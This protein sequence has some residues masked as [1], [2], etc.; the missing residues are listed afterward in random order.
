M[1]EQNQ[2]EFTPRPGEKKAQAIKAG[3]LGFNHSGKTMSALLMAR[4]I[5]GE[6]GNIIVVDTHNGQSEEYIGHPEIGRFQ[7]ID[8]KPPYS[9][10]RMLDAARSA[11]KHGADV[12]II[13]SFSNEWDGEGGVLQF[14]D[15][16]EVRLRKNNKKVGPNVWTEPKAY[17]SRLVNYLLGL[18]I[19]V[20]LCI[21]LKRVLDIESK[22]SIVS[23]ICDNNLLYELTLN[24]TIDRDTHTV[25][26][27][28]VGLRYQDCVKPGQK[29][30]S[31]TG[32]LLYAE[33]SKGH[34]DPYE[35]Q[36]SELENAARRGRDILTV[37]KDRMKEKEFEAYRDLFSRPGTAQRLGSLARE[38]DALKSQTSEDQETDQHQGDYDGN[39]P[40]DEPQQQT[41]YDDE[42]PFD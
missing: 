31:E 24:L 40:S 6:N 7:V 5:A 13:D 37:V 39:G 20:I 30:S 4:G 41:L 23:E 12:L 17:H 28:R 32:K 11:V 16:I 25:D 18:N 9:S 3:I 36:L 2:H 19:H 42:V 27:A 33:A 29:V 26:Q 22:K 14:K 15:E 34:I 8:L 21:R 1:T 10:L 35:K 38:A